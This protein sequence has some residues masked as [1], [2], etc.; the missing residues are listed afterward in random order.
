MSEANSDG[1]WGKEMD[2]ENHVGTYNGF[3]KG[4]T[5]GTIAVIAFVI[6]LAIITL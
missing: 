5:Y 3:I 6:L 4:A 2:V 1:V